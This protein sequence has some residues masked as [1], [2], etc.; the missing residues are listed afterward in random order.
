M[1]KKSQNAAQEIG[2]LSSGTVDLAEAAGLR[3]V[4]MLPKIS[5][6][7]KLVQQITT[8]SEEQNSGVGQINL[9]MTE[10]NISTQDLAA[11]SEE[12]ASTS[13]L[14]SDHAVELKQMIA[15]FKVQ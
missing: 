12:L 13:D 1:Q 6:T 4:E 8:A 14:L 3:L 7:A 5:E 9:G 10:L 11:S 2:E 15:F